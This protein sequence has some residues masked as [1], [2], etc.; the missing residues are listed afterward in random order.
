M[1]KKIKAE[2]D[3]N[4]RGSQQ[5][6]HKT[7]GPTRNRTVG[8]EKEKTR[9]GQAPEKIIRPVI[10]KI[11][12]ETLEGVRQRMPAG[13]ND[14]PSP[15]IF[16]DAGTPKD[17]AGQG[18]GHDGSERK[19]GQLAA[20]RAT[21]SFL[22]LRRDS[23]ADRRRVAVD[24]RRIFGDNSLNSKTPKAKTPRKTPCCFISTAT[25]NN[26]P[27][28]NKVSARRDC[29]PR[30][31]RTNPPSAA[32][33]TKCVAWARRPR[34]PGSLT[35]ARKL[36]WRSPPHKDQTTAKREKKAARLRPD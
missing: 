25:P 16:E 20:A 7:L 33:I 27:L 24:L 12:G 21:N 14:R 6:A 4:K 3:R 32:K 34:L 11:P 36:R 15:E 9:R 26:N 13:V 30:R 19:G 29:N 5:A 18:I 1:R 22:R 35:S 23:K 31:S 8:T 10:L 17:E 28:Q 2:S